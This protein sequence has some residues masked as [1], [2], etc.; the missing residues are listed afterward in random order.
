MSYYKETF[1]KEIK[2]RKER[3]ERGE[4]NGIPLCYN[5]YKDYVESIDKGV[6]Y[7][8]LS[9]PGEKQNKFGIL[10]YISYL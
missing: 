6:Y 4:Y 10:V 2:E 7:G 1:L 8:L 3:R 5:Q 9:G